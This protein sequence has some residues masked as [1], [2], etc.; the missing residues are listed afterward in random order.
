MCFTTIRIIC[1]FFIRI[2]DF[3]VRIIDLSTIFL[4]LCHVAFKN[5]NLFGVSAPV[6]QVFLFHSVHE[7][8]SEAHSLLS[9]TPEREGGASDFPSFRSV[10][11][12]SSCTPAELEQFILYSLFSVFDVPR[13]AKK[14][15]QEDIRAIQ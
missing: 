9:G 7:F 2:I 13:H 3:F 12:G 10:A 8:F 6:E 4:Y 14:P 15:N 1:G 11:S 5:L